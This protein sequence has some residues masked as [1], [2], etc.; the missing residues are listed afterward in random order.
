[1]H[2]HYKTF[3]KPNKYKSKKKKKAF[4]LAPEGGFG[5]LYRNL[6]QHPKTHCKYICN[7]RKNSACWAEQLAVQEKVPGLSLNG[8]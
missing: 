6:H 8:F 1:M 3:R 4:R 7:L 2:A 5:G